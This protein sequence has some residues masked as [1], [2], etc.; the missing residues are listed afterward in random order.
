MRVDQ[1]AVAK[2][3]ELIVEAVIT[4]R[5]LSQH[6]GIELPDKVGQGWTECSRFDITRSLLNEVR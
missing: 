4:L 3:L 5:P 6:L 1:A 2:A